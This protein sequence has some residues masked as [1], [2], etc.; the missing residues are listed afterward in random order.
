[1]WQIHFQ[2]FLGNPFFFSLVKEFPKVPSASV[3]STSS[4]LVSHSAPVP[5]LFPV[6][7]MESFWVQ[8]NRGNTGSGYCCQSCKNYKNTHAVGSQ[9]SVW[10]CSHPGR[11]HSNRTSFMVLGGRRDL[12]ALPENISV[13]VTNLLTVKSGSF[14]VWFVLVFNR[15]N[16]VSS[17]MKSF[18][19]LTFLGSFFSLIF[20]VENTN[21]IL[22]WI[23]LIQTAPSF[24]LS[25]LQTSGMGCFPRQRLP[26]HPSRAA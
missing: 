21:H 22:F 24:P 15:K 26:F 10:W 16:Y 7:L 12:Q 2:S 3:S 17:N 14:L 11:G 20:W 13:H 18:A 8:G 6:L 5:I 25:P 19:L 4:E 23:R 9:N 1:M